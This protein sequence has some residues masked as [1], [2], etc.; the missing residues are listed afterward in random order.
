MSLRVRNNVASINSL[1]HLS[2]SETALS[3][4]LERLASGQRIN[5]AGDDPAGLIISENLRAEIS[6]IEQAISNSEFTVSMVQTAEG[7]LTEVNNLLIEGRQLALNAAN[8]G[9]NDSNSLQALQEQLGNALQSIDRVSTD[10][11]FGNK[12]LLD[13]S[14][15]V[16]GVSNGEGLAFVS[17]N[18]RTQSSPIEGYDV[19]V[20]KFAKRSVTQATLTEDEVKGLRV[21]LA[22]G[23]KS[24]TVN[25]R[26]DDSPETFAG[27]VKDQVIAANL[28]LDVSFDRSS[29]AIVIQH[30]LYGKDY[31]FQVSSN[32]DGIL[33]GHANTTEL[34]S[35]GQDIEGHINGEAATG[36]G[37]VLIGNRNNRTTEGLAVRYSNES[38]Q[39]GVVGKISVSQ[40][41]L[42]FQV[43]PNR[44]QTARVAIDDTSSRS[45]AKGIDNESGFHDLSEV[46][47]TTA[48]GAQDALLF[49]D[50]AINNVSKVRGRLGS[51]QKNSLESNVATLKITAENL[52]AAES[53]IRDTD[54]AKELAEF[55]KQQILS[56]VASSATL[57]ANGLS[58]QAAVLLE[59]GL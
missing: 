3:S 39:P 50:E 58:R 6:G 4:S 20:T 59:R 40:N 34:V 32:R 19:E 51:F 46:N 57:H 41:S 2:Q 18:E 23:G 10:T 48:K 9:A 38:A 37:D 1:R 29:G 28:D 49:L 52:V 5:R 7:A 16:S 30:Q 55:T 14:R 27:R 24:V 56:Q 26:A 43:G 33:T 54:V 42:T 12:S 35:N 31:A 22:E 15:G 45:L 25:A 36:Q 11:R 17:A 8:E 47:I 53:S 13:G 21:S 44:G